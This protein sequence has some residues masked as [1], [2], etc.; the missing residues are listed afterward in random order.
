MK[1]FQKL[2]YFLLLVDL[3]W[4]KHVEDL[5]L[6][7]AQT[8]DECIFIDCS[9][10]YGTD[11]V[12][13]NK[14][15]KLTT[16]LTTKKALLRNGKDYE[17]L[18]DNES[19]DVLCRGPN[20]TK[21]KE[22]PLRSQ[23]SD[24]KK[25]GDL[26]LSQNEIAYI[27]G[28]LLQDFQID[29]ADFTHNLIQNISDD[30]FSQIYILDTLDLSNNLLEYISEKTFEPLSFNLKHL[31]ISSNWL[32]K[33]ETEDL[34]KIISKLQDLRTLRL[35]H[36]HI[37]KLPDLSQLTKLEE[38]GLSNNFIEKITHREDDSSAIKLLPDSLVSLVLDNNHL[39]R[40]DD[41]TLSNLVN[42]KYLNLANNQIS[43]ISSNAFIHLTQ[44]TQLILAKN[45]I[46][47]IPS[48]LFLKQSILERIDLSDQNQMLKSL[49]DYTFEREMNQNPIRRVDLSK[50]RITSISNKT[51]CTSR[52]LDNDGTNSYVNIKDLDISN[53]PL[54]SIINACIWRQLSLGSNKNETQPTRVS[55]KSFDFMDKKIQ[56][57][58]KCDCEITK[59][60]FYV[61]FEGEC[62]NQFGIP[63]SLSQYKCTRNDEFITFNETDEKC[64][65]LFEFDCT[66]TVPKLKTTTKINYT[67]LTLNK[68]KINLDTTTPVERWLIDDDHDINND[69]SS[70]IDLINKASSSFCNNSIYIFFVIT[71]LCIF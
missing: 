63:V 55:F 54:T 61:G 20:S 64:Q 49:D 2:I 11:D 53:N 56:P 22:F 9:C 37:K 68:K 14:T 34:S 40:I 58:L 10:N 31:A 19:V 45:F 29:I 32:G 71:L 51:F 27:P 6:R 41:S 43:S 67:Q 8:D 69:N 28:G 65:K 35:N 16:R 25:I 62:T 42:L 1:F 36:N 4:T 13:S 17:Y 12:D 7:A 38:I 26:D 66:N 50:N 24:T 15:T 59:S 52:I 70:N 3:I 33:M 21:L 47:H 5:T 30:A 60:S 48:R 57:L 46:K 23:K 44:L 18:D 39:K